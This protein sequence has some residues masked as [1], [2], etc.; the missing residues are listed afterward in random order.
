MFGSRI[1]WRTGKGEKEDI[2]ILLIR[3]FQNKE[4][5]VND[6]PGLDKLN[7]I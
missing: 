7:Y 3:D 1:Y 5:P 6:L 2:H 4:V